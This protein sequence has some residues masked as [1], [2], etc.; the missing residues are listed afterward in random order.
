[1]INNRV[2]GLAEKE[3]NFKVLH[4]NPTFSTHSLDYKRY[5]SNKIFQMADNTPSIMSR[6]GMY[7]NVNLIAKPCETI[8]ERS[9]N[10]QFGG[11]S[12][13]DFKVKAGTGLSRQFFTEDRLGLSRSLKQK[14]LINAIY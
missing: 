1:M 11:Y 9:N 13:D 10:R 4:P 14:P 5:K 7:Q 12:N 8:N 3:R 6:V 2:I